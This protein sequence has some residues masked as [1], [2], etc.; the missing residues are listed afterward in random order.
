[1]STLA[2][3]PAACPRCKSGY[4]SSNSSNSYSDTSFA[5]GTRVH[6]DE[7]GTRMDARCKEGAAPICSNCDG[8]GCVC[9][10]VRDWDSA[11]R[12]DGHCCPICSGTGS[13]EG[14]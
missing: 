5:C 2:E 11:Q 4:T 7:S 6:I 13:A 3:A 12:C 1:M 14:A 8:G 9:I 10:V